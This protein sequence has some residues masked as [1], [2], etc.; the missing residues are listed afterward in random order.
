MPAY[1]V[2]TVATLSEI[3]HD[4]GLRHEVSHFVTEML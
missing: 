4:N 1:E 2:P 3:M